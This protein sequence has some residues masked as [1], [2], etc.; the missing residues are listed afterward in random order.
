M[1][2]RVV[3][4]GLLL[5]AGRVCSTTAGEPVAHDRGKLSEDKSTRWFDLKV[6]EVEGQAWKETKAPFD[7]F[8][9][10]AEKKVRDAVWGLSRHSA[11]LCARF[12]TSATSIKARWT[13][14]AARLEMPHMPATGAQQPNS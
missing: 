1:N 11:G 3:V 8:P 6:L 12:E 10:K 7:R 5:I 9:A 2:L 4:L 14:T 13:L